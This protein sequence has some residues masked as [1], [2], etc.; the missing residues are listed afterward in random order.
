[1]PQWMIKVLATVV[2]NVV[3]KL[4]EWIVAKLEE[5]KRE[6]EIKA[7]AKKGIKDVKKIKDR[8]ER[9]KAMDDYLSFMRDRVREPKA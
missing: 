8:K 3:V 5:K 7:E 9:A 1:M 2:T 4:G 6:A